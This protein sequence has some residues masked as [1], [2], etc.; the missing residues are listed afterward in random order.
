MTDITKPTKKTT[1]KTVDKNSLTPKDILVKEIM[2][3]IIQGGTNLN[4]V[5]LV[6]KATKLAEVF[7]LKAE[8]DL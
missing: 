1:K 3:A 2:L 8:G 5:L 6:N 7:I 4:D